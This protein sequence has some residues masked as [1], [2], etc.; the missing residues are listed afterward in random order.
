MEL[1]S[2]AELLTRGPEGSEPNIDGRSP[3]RAWIR[4]ADGLREVE[5]RAVLERTCVLAS[6]DEANVRW[7]VR[8]REVL[9]D[10]R[11]F[12]WR[13]I[14]HRPGVW[15]PGAANRGRAQGRRS[16]AATR[17]PNQAGG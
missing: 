10:E 17:Q 16:I 6:L 4:Q 11:T 13:A 12:T 5:L 15:A 14:P 2:V 7:L 1:V 8:R 3:A 9:V